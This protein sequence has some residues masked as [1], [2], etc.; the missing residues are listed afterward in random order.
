MTGGRSRDLFHVQ[1][2]N[3]LSVN[4]PEVKRL[5]RGSVILRSLTKG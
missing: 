5:A 2:D 4:E 1:H 3:A